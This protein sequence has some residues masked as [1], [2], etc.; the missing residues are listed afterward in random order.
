MADQREPLHRTPEEV[1]E[2]EKFFRWYGAWAP[3]DPAGVVELL[4]GFEPA[5]V[6]RRRV[7]DRGVHRARP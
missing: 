3:L 7:V 5:V 2:D 1:A 4:A 6:D